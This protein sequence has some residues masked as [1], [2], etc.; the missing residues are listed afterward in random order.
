MDSCLTLKNP[1]DENKTPEEIEKSK[2]DQKVAAFLSKSFV[3]D[4]MYPKN[5]LMKSILMMELF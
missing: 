3:K 1:K 4:Y 5:S 2:E